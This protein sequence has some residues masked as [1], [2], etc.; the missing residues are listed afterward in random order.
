MLWVQILDSCKESGCELGNWNIFCEQCRVKVYPHSGCK[1]V[2]KKMTK[3]VFGRW[4][5]EEHRPPAPISKQREECFYCSNNESSH[6]MTPASIIATKHNVRV[7]SCA[8][9]MHLRVMLVNYKS[10]N[11]F[12]TF[13]DPGPKR[14]IHFKSGFQFLCVLMSKTVPEKLRE[15]VW[16]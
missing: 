5:D 16:A 7:K 6:F 13:F 2:T 15:C 10:P 8:V 12:L 14:R 11:N 3:F 1:S 9:E 4:Q